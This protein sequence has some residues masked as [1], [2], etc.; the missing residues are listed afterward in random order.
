MTELTLDQASKLVDLTLA[1]A[2]EMKLKPLTVAVLDAGGHLKAFKREDA[3]G[4]LRPQI[5]IGKA[6][7]ALA[8]GWGT[9]TLAA[10]AAT[11]PHFVAALSDISGGKLV[12]VPGGVIIKDASGSVIG[13]IGVSGDTSDNDEAAAMDAIKKV[14]LQGDPGSSG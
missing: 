14:G 7:G 12:P 11:V 13:A 6:W 4:I 2:H 9:R 5:A 10:R 8:M 1:R 3:P